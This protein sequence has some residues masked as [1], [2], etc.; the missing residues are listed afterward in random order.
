MTNIE[1][2]NNWIRLIIATFNILYSIHCWR[3]KQRINKSRIL[4]PVFDQQLYRKPVIFLDSDT[5][6]KWRSCDSSVYKW[7]L[8]G[9][10]ADWS[11]DGIWHTI[12]KQ[13]KQQKK[14]FEWTITT[15]PAFVRRPCLFFCM[16]CINTVRMSK[17]GEGVRFG[18]KWAKWAKYGTL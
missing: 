1:I 18:H 9:L 12:G 16:Y 15:S 5:L 10:I 3:D 4:Y 11:I 6:I 13:K 7:N 17:V 2:L 14:T 8:I